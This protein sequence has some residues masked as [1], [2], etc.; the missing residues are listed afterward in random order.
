MREMRANMRR[1][2]K[3]WRVE[4][5]FDCDLANVFRDSPE[6][7]TQFNNLIYNTLQRNRSMLLYSGIQTAAWVPAKRQY[8]YE[9]ATT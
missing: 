7:N 5:S 4:V 3:R 2:K 1:N 9:H 8:R 6:G